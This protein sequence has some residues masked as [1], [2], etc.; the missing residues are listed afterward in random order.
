MLKDCASISFV[1]VVD[2][3]AFPDPTVALKDC[4]SVFFTFGAAASDRTV[5]LEDCESVFLDFA[6]AGFSN[7]LLV[8]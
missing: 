1:L 5:A 8:D 3:V 6:D 7:L 4:V 2:A